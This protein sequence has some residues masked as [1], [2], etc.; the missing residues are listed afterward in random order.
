MNGLT[1]CSL[2]VNGSILSDIGSGVKRIVD[3]DKDDEMIVEAMLFVEQD[4]FNAG[5]RIDFGGG[6]DQ[7]SSDESI[8]GR[9]VDP[10][11]IAGCSSSM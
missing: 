5:R 10:L 11:I 3:F 1:L 7:S 6:A 8:E 4:L 2:G 9:G